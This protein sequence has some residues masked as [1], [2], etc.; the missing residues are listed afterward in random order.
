VEK[1]A[2]SIIGLGRIAS[3]LEMDKLRE[4]PA[5]HAGAIV[6][7][8]N[9]FLLS[10]CDP[11]PEKRR[12]FKEQWNCNRVF[13]DF[14][15]MMH[16][17]KPDILH[18]ATPADSHGYYVLRAVREKIPLVVCEKP[19][20]RTF[21][22]ARRIVRIASSSSTALLVNH[23]R[24]YSRDYMYVKNRIVQKAFGT[25]LSIHARLYMGYNRTVNEMFYEDG[26]HMIDIIRFLTGSEIVP[27]RSFGN[28]GAKG[29]GAIIVA[30]VGKI[31]LVIE[32]GCNRDHL[33]FELDLSFGNGRIRIGNGLLEEYE[34][35]PSPF[36][37][38]FKSLIKKEDRID[39]IFGN[40]GY[41]TGM[42]RDAVK[43]VREKTRPLS[44][45]SDGYL[46]LKSIHDLLKHLENLTA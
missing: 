39:N 34:S 36:Y 26:T 10:G 24:R 5:T 6:S 40:T 7:N 29:G 28:A 11:D 41:F 37:E 3:L 31:P 14:E 43:V 1:I 8:E 25:L 44:S 20:A 2:C 16:F 35:M 13:A 17:K 19:L 4:K 30:R 27:V 33:V 9:C 15:E 22:E 42:M 46:A 23:E 12:V 18:I 32:A 45:G 21:R 38:K